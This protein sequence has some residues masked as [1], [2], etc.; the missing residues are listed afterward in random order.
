MRERMAGLLAASLL[1]SVAMC[2]VLV[3]AAEAAVGV[4]AAG[5]GPVSGGALTSGKPVPGAVS[6]AAGIEY[7]FTAVA[8]KHVTV[9]ITQAD[10]MPYP[11]Q[12]SIQAFDRK[13]AADTK[14]VDFG[15]N[16]NH[17]DINFTATAAEA[18]T[19]TVIVR[20]ST[21]NP[22]ATGSFTITY[23]KDVTGKLTSGKARNGAIASEGQRAEYTFTAV[24]GKHV[25]VAITQADVMPYPQQLS[26]Q[27]FDRKGAADTKPVDFGDNNN[28]VDINFTATAAE[29]GTTTV[30]VRPSTANPAATGSF[31]ITYAKDVTGKLTSGKARNGAIASEGQRAEYTFTAV[32]GKHV[33]ITITNADISPYP[34]ELSIQAFDRKGKADTK[35]AHFGNGGTTPLS[36]TPTAREAGTTTIIIRPSSAYPQ[37]TGSFTITYRR[38]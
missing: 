22:A 5:G 9:A 14:P 20:P 27:A 17:V 19:T 21:A 18:G 31:T 33:T 34:A 38:R 26:I 16:N 4:A 28:H 12:L 23:A 36:F 30:I 11:Q 15:D 6:A 35:P 2:L 3:P 8:G 37:A 13:G 32:A 25:T 7:T 29:A 10:V 1:G 24:A